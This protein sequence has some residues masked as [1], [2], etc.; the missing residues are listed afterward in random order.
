MFVPLLA[1]ILCILAD[2]AKHGGGA[3]KK[4]VDG[5]RALVPLP[6]SVESAA[7]ASVQSADAT[8]RRAEETK[9]SA[10]ASVAAAKAAASAADFALAEIKSHL[11]SS[12]ALAE[13]DLSMVCRDV[14]EVEGIR[15][16]YLEKS[17]SLN[18][19]MDCLFN[20]VYVKEGTQ[21]KVCLTRGKITVKCLDPK[22]CPTTS[23]SKP[24][25]PQSKPAKHE[26][27]SVSK[28]ESKPSKPVPGSESVSTSLST[29][30]STATGLAIVGGINHIG[31]KKK[32]DQ[33]NVKT[34][35]ELQVAESS[36]NLPSLPKG[37]AGHTVDWV[38]G[39]LVACG[40]IAC[41]H[42]VDGEWQSMLKTVKRRVMHSSTV[43][44]DKILLV[45]GFGFPNTS[46]LVPMD[47]GESVASFDPLPGRRYHCAI[48]TGEDKVVLT[49]G[50]ETE[51]L[52]TEYSG[53][54]EGSVVIRKKLPE[55][56]TGRFIHACGHYEI[57]G[58]QMLMVTGGQN[59]N[60]VDVA[61]TEVFDYY[62]EKKGNWRVVEALL[63]TARFGLRGA[64]VDG[65]LYVSGGLIGNQFLD[66]ILRWEPRE[67]MWIY[68]GELDT[69]RALHAIVEVNLDEL[70]EYCA[71]TV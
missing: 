36:C 17:T 47:G 46:E 7:A 27:G 4:P 45:G 23:I 53:I 51:F 28:A 15:Y 32:K 68:G 16:N 62:W 13:S 56:S 24:A 11:T 67:E 35:V 26:S 21:I 38:Q 64:K 61:T 12:L 66:E 43:L 31:P 52:V 40:G 9:E 14:E 33:V 57:D 10:D 3:R 59:K 34:S 22:D 29:R 69:S 6:D 65:D 63:P 37:M 18:E 30:P 2:A 44:G 25:K 5:E 55:L 71:A 39:K 48:K 54:K 70:A 8:L 41:Y 60:E 58:R 42:L 20:C 49:G 1:A 19:T 50:W